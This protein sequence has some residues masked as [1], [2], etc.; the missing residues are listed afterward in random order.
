MPVL[1]TT[2]SQRNG[3]LA[4]KLSIDHQKFSS[5]IASV[6][7]AASRKKSDVEGNLLF[8]YSCYH[9]TVE[10][11]NGILAIRRNLPVPEAT[12][13]GKFLVPASLVSSILS[14]TRGKKE[15]VSINV[16]DKIVIESGTARY[17]I[18]HQN[19]EIFPKMHDPSQDESPSFQVLGSNLSQVLRRTGFVC[20]PENSQ[21]SIPGIYL[22]Y[23]SD[24]LR[25][26]GSSRGTQMVVSSVPIENTDL[27]RDALS[28]IIPVIL[29]EILV[30]AFQDADYPISI[31]ILPNT[32]MISDGPY[33]IVSA[34]MEGKPPPFER[35]LQIP[36]SEQRFD[37]T[38]DDLRG[39][40]QNSMILYDEETRGVIFRSNGNHRIE[41]FGE[42]AVQGSSRVYRDI[43]SEVP[44]FNVKI[45]PSMVIA[46]CRRFARDDIAT[47]Q[48]VSYPGDSLV[49]DVNDDYRYAIA[50]M[51]K[52]DV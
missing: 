1:R 2:T 43:D 49:I 47:L 44:D 34:L 45:D 22:G 28:G 8:S 9:C 6:S 38:I 21:Y 31:N 42:S 46:F 50:L 40:F 5:I 16:D 11:T 13:D 37:V 7:R 12:E 29:V 41:A 30:S 3:Q 24:T 39:L 33:L 35:I 23:S 10:A 36:K 27:E 18:N 51:E 20:D 52:R 25:V 15:D 17:E 19:P 32:F 48:I 26:V 4:V 14:A